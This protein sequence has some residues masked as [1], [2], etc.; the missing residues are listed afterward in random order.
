MCLSVG[1][2]HALSLT[3]NQII[4][5]GNLQKDLLLSETLG[6]NKEDILPLL[7]DQLFYFQQSLIK[8]PNK[9]TVVLISKIIKAINM[10]NANV[11]PKSALDYIFLV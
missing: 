10:I 9:E 3:K 5:T 8:N 7:Q 6:K 11:D 1:T 2:R 4:I